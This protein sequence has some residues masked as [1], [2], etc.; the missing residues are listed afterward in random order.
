MMENTNK[1]LYANDFQRQLS[2]KIRGD[3]KL[4]IENLCLNL[5]LA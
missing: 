2:E 5:K 1:H 4:S 3:G